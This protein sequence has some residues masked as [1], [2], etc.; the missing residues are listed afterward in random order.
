MLDALH[1]GVILLDAGGD[2]RYANPAALDMLGLPAPD[3]APVPVEEWL[4]GL[5]DDYSRSLRTTIEERGQTGL[6]HPNVDRQYLRFEARPLPGSDDVICLVRRDQGYEAVE[7][8]A[9]LIHAIRTPMTAINGGTAMLKLID[10]ES[11]TDR[12]HQLVDTITRA[13]KRLESSLSAVGEMTRIDR[14][15]ITLKP[16]PQSPLKAV[17]RALESFRSLAQ[18][19][20]HHVTLDLP[21]D[22]PAVQ[23]DPERFEQ[24]L[25][26]LLDNAFKYTPPGGQIHVRGRVASGGMVQIDVADD[27]LGIPAGEQERVFQKFFR[28]D[29]YRIHE[30]PGLGLHLYIARGLVELHGGRLWFESAEGEGSTFSFTLPVEEL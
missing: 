23:A 2:V 29:D 8:I 28:G 22:L 17:A 20:N 11:L 18:E 30:Y 16:E 24:V 5:G 10:A 12:Q 19:K 26:I 7:V 1:E 4:A 27:G 9:T 3:G 6:P 21:P 14:D 25:H 13:A 15:R